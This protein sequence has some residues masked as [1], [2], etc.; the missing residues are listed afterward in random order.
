MYHVLSDYLFI[1]AFKEITP[2]CL[3]VLNPPLKLSAPPF[4]FLCDLDKWSIS[5]SLGFSSHFFQQVLYLIYRKMLFTTNCKTTWTTQDIRISLPS[6]L[7]PPS[8]SLSFP[9]P[10]R[11]LVKETKSLLSINPFNFTDIK[12]L[13]TAQKIRA[14]L[15]IG[16]S[17]NLWYAGSAGPSEAQSDFPF[18]LVM[19]PV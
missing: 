12:L 11:F 6:F 10:A 18:L 8:P 7:L 13:S 3:S 14:I 16:A 2:S 9:F 5:L 17:G 1:L 19:S 4:H 15:Q